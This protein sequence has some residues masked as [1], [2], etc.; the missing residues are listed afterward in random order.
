MNCS[1]IELT[2][3]D[4][5]KAVSFENLYSAARECE[6]NGTIHKESTQK[7]R[8]ND[9]LHTADLCRLVEKD[10]YEILKYT[11]FTLYVPKM[12]HIKATR[13]RDR[14]LQKSLCNNGLYEAFTQNFIDGNVAC[15]KDKGMVFGINLLKHHLKDYY[16]IYHTHKG[17]WLKL[18][19]KG[20]FDNTPHYL[21]KQT[22]ADTL[23][24]ENFIN[25]VFKIIDSFKDER[26]L[27]EI[28]NDE[29]GERGVHLGSQISQLLQL[30]Y[31][32]DLDHYVVEELGIKH[33]VRYMDDIV[34]LFKSKYATKRV[35]K[36]VEK[37]LLEKKG[38]RLNTRKSR[39]GRLTDNVPFLKILFKL[40]CSGK[41]HVRCKNKTYQKEIKRIRKLAYI[42]FFERE[43]PNKRKR[44]SLE[45]FI[46][47]GNYWFGFAQWR[48][49]K[50]QIRHM[51]A[52][53]EDIIK[54]HSEKLKM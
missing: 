22:V 26:S 28:V 15:Q 42:Y 27:E 10:K 12:R 21:L 41:V 4:Y 17:Y 1:K 14:A 45:Q 43:N 18:D 8:M 49:S 34:M 54:E 53:Y 33:Y 24:Q 47:H 13:I 16:K 11:D 31:L 40:S 7:F 5:L 46:M 25:H 52:F 38:L 35:W 30:N 23:K 37:F 44:L 32:N 6:G 50:G 19:I 2:Y 51:R 36:A 20:Y 9:L 29:Y 39:I 3:D 48:C